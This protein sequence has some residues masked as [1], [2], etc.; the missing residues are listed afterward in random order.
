ME[1]FHQFRCFAPPL[2]AKQACHSFN[3]SKCSITHGFI[4][5][6]HFPFFCN[7]H[8]QNTIPLLLIIISIL[9]CRTLSVVFGL[10]LPRQAVEGRVASW[11]TAIYLNWVVLWTGEQKERWCSIRNS[12]ID[13]FRA[14]FFSPA[15]T[16]RQF[17]SA[18]PSSSFSLIRRISSKAFVLPF[19]TCA[20]LFHWM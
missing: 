4:I 1:F 3:G 20:A 12:S 9:F 15:S 7:K 19:P 16:V 14:F 17:I 11:N 5:M 6:Q 13:F 2:A 10:L 18:T 8:T